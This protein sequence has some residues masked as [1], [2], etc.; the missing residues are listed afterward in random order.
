MIVAVTTWGNR[1]S[2]VFDAAGTLLIADIENKAV[3]RQ[4]YVSFQPSN[5]PELSALLQRFGATTLICGAI[6]ARPATRLMDNGIELLS[7]VSGNTSEILSTFARKK[8]V[9]R[10]QMM[11]GCIPKT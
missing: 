10:T 6:S 9:D 2:P 11:P 4:T 7:F 1:V 8:A 3:T 5:I